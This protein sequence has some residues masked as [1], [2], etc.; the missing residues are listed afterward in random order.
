[1]NITKVEPP[2]WWAGMKLNK[3]Q[4]MVYGKDLDNAK[5]FFNDNQVKVLAVH[6][7]ESLSY[8]FVDIEIPSDIKPGSYKLT[9]KKNG[10]E[11]VVNFPIL[12]RQNDAGKYQGFNNEDVLYL[13][14]PD[15]FADGDAS[16]NVVKGM[17]DECDVQNPI[18]R[19]GGDIQGIIDH[20]DYLKNLNISTLWIC[21][22]LENNTDVHYYGYAGYS[23]T[24]LYKVDARLGTNE[25]Y[26]KLVDDVHAKGMKII[27]D[28]VSNHIS[29]SH[30]WMNDL[31]FADWIN[32]SVKQHLATRHDKLAFADIHRDS[33]TIINTTKGWF[34][35]YLPDLNQANPYVSNYLIENTIWWIESTGLDGIREDTYPYSDQI[36][37]SNW[38]KTILEEYPKLNIVGEVWTG[39][40]VFLSSFQKGNYYP[41]QIDSNLP[42]VTDFSTYDTYTAFLRG[43]A[44]LQNI[45]EDYAKDFIYGNPQNLVTFMD[46][47]D[48]GRALMQAGGD[49]KKFE[50]V[51]TMLLTSRGIPELFYGTEIGMMGGNDDG[52]V[53]SDFPGGFAGDKHNAFTKEGRTKS[54]DIIYDYLSTLL[55][56]RKEHKALSEG[57]L[58][59]YPPVDNVF[60]YFKNYD[61]D[62]VMVI[63]NNNSDEK[64]IDLSRFSDQLKDV[65]NIKNL[66]TGKTYNFTD[67]SINVESESG[68]LFLLLK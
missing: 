13:I 61:N 48:V 37:L 26:K 60:V 58:I 9:L 33:S 2:N 66:T 34:T 41:R 64:E 19:H 14:M 4:L 39:D 42:A 56:L 30:P 7:A 1:M 6:N 52:T 59:Q 22:V 35:N 27:L 10:I 15:R 63:M 36:Y 40:A 16:N 21:P 53:R 29:I 31:P 65:K 45:Y 62:R 3:I 28:H 25:L 57:K 44:G 24:D 50:M 49:V 67:N 18:A 38:A 32:G 20:L 54:E 47:H 8:L 46:N 5:A 51:V 17:P 55:N 23:A 11:K 68:N 43:K 12:A